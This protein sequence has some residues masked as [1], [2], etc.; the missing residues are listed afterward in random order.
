MNTRSSLRHGEGAGWR[1][2]GLPD[3][4]GQTKLSVAIEDRETLTVPV[5]LTTNRIDN[6]MRL[7]LA[8]C[9]KR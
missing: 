8:I 4:S 5:Q 2:K 9:E 1:E 3:V 7:M 6:H